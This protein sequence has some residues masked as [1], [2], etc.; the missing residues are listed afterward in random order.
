MNVRSGCVGALVLGLIMI[1]QAHA[2]APLPP[3]KPPFFTGVDF[4]VTTAGI[5]SNGLGLNLRFHASTLIDL[6]ESGAVLSYSVR[7]HQEDTFMSVYGGGFGG[8]NAE[9]QPVGTPMG[10]MTAVYARQFFQLRAWGHILGVR[11][12]KGKIGPAA[13]F[14]FSAAGTPVN[15]DLFRLD[16]GADVEGMNLFLMG[17][18]FAA[19]ELKRFHLGTVDLAARFQGKF[20][21]ACGGISTSC[22][23]ALAFPLQ[24]TLEEHQEKKVLPAFIE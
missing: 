8:S 18:A 10:G 22:S 19:F 14:L 7:P 6:Q 11:G 13:N 21:L 17:A 9:R 24:F 2:Q 1:P 20:T 12:I 23:G 4:S 16:L 15:T 3:K 5:L